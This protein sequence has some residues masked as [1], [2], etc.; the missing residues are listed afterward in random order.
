MYDFIQYSLYIY[1]NK[2]Y[3]TESND[4]KINIVLSVWKEDKK[5][6]IIIPIMYHLPAF[7][8]DYMYV[9]SSLIDQKELSDH[10]CADNH[11]INEN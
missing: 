4:N 3:W 6:S 1:I 11:I 7:K 10:F 2:E 8:I 5:E 9:V